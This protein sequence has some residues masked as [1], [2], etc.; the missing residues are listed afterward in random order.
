MKFPWNEKTLNWFKTASAYTGF[1]RRLASIVRP[2]IA[3]CDT[4]CDIG[5]GLGLLDL[6]LARDVRSALCVD[7]NEE[8]IEALR[9]LILARGV[10]NVAARAM[11][12]DALAGER[13]DAVILSFFGTSVADISRFMSFCDKRMILIVH[14]SASALG[15]ATARP[16]RTKPLGA[17]EV[18]D[19]LTGCGTRFRKIGASLEFGQPF[20]SA[21]DARDFLRVYATATPLADAA[22]DWERLCEDTEKR[23]V[24]T[25]RPEYPLYL[26]K[27]KELAV[28]VAENR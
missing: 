6:E 12:A 24:E 21:A 22:A 10:H 7:R 28:F 13:W 1:H 5:C 25:G 18:A 23:L 19:F 17:D 8:A 26:P 15:C 11:D 2:H 14:E 27:R 3:D 20:K 4:L 9:A 16:R